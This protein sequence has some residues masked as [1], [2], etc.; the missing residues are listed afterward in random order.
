MNKQ[1]IIRMLSVT[2]CKTYP[3]QEG[4]NDEI[5]PSHLSQR[6]KKTKSQRMDQEF[7]RILGPSE[8]FWAFNHLSRP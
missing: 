6:I 8:L 4:K 3:F 7:S 5:C 2:Y 1:T